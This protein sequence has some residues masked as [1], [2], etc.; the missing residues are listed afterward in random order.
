MGCYF[1]IV[2]NERETLE[3]DEAGILF[4]NHFHILRFSS[5]V[6]YQTKYSQSKVHPCLSK[7]V[8]E[9]TIY[10]RI[11]MQD[12]KYCVYDYDKMESS[13]KYFERVLNSWTQSKPL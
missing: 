8:D 3:E 6:I 9:Q 5:I 12:G 4:L 13:S 10:K 1:E 11:L 2:E 7:L